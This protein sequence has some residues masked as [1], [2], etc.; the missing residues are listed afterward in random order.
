M[1]W[2]CPVCASATSTPMWEQPAGDVVAA[3]DLRPS[4]DQFGKTSGRVVRCTT[5]GHGSLEEPPTAEVLSESYEDAADEVSL[6]EEAGQVETARRALTLVEGFVEP[7]RVVDLGCWTGS[8]LVGAR[9]RGWD[10][11]GIEPSTWGSNRARERGLDVRTSEWSN[12]GLD[13]GSFRLVVMADVIEHLIDPGA[14][15]DEI[16]KLLEPGGALML[17]VPDAGSRLARTMR[18]RWWSVL[19]M[20]VQY[21]TRASMRRLL[22]AHGYRVLLM[23]THAKV[24]SAR[25]YAER[26]AGY[27]SLLERAVLA[28][29]RLTRQT[30]RLVA[31]DFRDRMLV[32]ATPAAN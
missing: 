10:T 30:E 28:P 6:R 15:L 32:L 9:E 8:F 22:E 14:A 7:G 17:T 26:L 19:P 31:P 23:R 29:L 1:S 27:S 18:R 12:H 25:Y 13:P 3:D 20:H 11:V 21:F 24:F 4:S 5:C 16:A 2:T